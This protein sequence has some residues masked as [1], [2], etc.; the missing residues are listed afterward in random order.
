MVGEEAKLD[1]LA[2]AL[3]SDRITLGQIRRR[4][5][6]HFEEYLPNTD[7]QLSDLN[8][9]ST[10]A[11]EV[12]LAKCAYRAGCGGKPM[13]LRER[14]RHIKGLNADYILYGLSTGMAKTMELV[15]DFERASEAK[16]RQR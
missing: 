3:P 15:R 5:P 9:A 2:L 14:L 10:V 13:P 6:E 7:D 1:L 4:E 12:L 16:A 8:I 11:T